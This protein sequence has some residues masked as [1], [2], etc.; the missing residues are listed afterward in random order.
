[1]LS[2]LKKIWKREH[3]KPVCGVGFFHTGAKDSFSDA[4][5]YHDEQY[6]LKD[7]DRD[8]MPCEEDLGIIYQTKS[9]LQVD[10]IFLHKML[11]V[12]NAFGFFKRALLKTKAYTYNA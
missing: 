8:S 6:V 12:A 5:S 3:A 2:L 7:K 4:C 9:R 11:F 1:M 10:R